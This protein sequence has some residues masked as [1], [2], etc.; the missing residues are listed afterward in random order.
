MLLVMGTYILTEERDLQE[1]KA[2]SP[3]NSVDEGIVKDVRL[4]QR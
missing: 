3:I 1:E 4:S 2:K